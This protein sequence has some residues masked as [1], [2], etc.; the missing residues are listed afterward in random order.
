[1]SKGPQSTLRISLDE[2]PEAIKVALDGILDRDT[3]PEL[4]VIVNKMIL[5]RKNITL[6]LA[7]LRLIDPT[8]VALIVSAFKRNR[9]QGKK[10]EI[11]GLQGQPR[12]MFLLLEFDKVFSL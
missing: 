8:G 7:D 6:Q 9:E 5:L 4:R 11:K 3:T 1:M 10:V 12:A 2:E